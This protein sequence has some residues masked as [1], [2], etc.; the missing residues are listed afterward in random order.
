[1]FLMAKQDPGASAIAAR[2]HTLFFLATPHRGS[3]FASTLNNLLKLA[4]GHGSKFYVDDLYPH[5]E[6]IQ[7][8]ND[9][10]RHVYQG[11]NLYSFFETVPTTLGLIV[12]KTSAVLELPGEQISHL[13]ADHSHVCKFDTPSDSDYIRLRDAFVSTIS[14]IQKT[15]LETQNH[16]RIDDLET[17]SRY[18]G[19]KEQ[20][21]V[22]HANIIEH[23][24]AGSCS[25]LTDNDTF[26]EWMEDI[27]KSPRC[28]WL[29]GEPGSGKSTLASHVVNYLEVSNNN[30]AYFFFKHLHTGK[31]TQKLLD[32]CGGGVA[33][34][35]K[36]ERSIWR[37]IFATRILCVQF[38][39]PQYWVIDGLDECANPASL[40]PLLAKIEKKVWLRVFVTSRPSLVFE[41]AFSRED[42]A[43][44]AETIPL[45]A[46]LSDIRLYLNEHSSYFLCESEDE[47]QELVHT[48]L[49]MSNGN[50]LWT[51]LVVKRIENAVSKEQVHTILNSVPKEMDQLYREITSSIMASP[52]TAPIAKA[53]LR[54]TL[55]SLQPLSVDELREAL[56][57]DIGENLNQLDKTAGAI[58]GNLVYDDFEYGMQREREHTRIT[59]V[60]LAYLS[61]DDMK[62]RRFRRANSHAHKEAKRSIFS[63]YAIVYFSDHI[64][65]SSSSSGEQLAALNKFLMSN[66]TTWIEAIASTKDLTPLTQ[67]ANNLKAYMDRRAK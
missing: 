47:R 43:S 62:P 61:G 39:Q 18:L 44:I 67:T 10:F 49:D 3:N 42:I 8:I 4:V 53:I 28:Y 17:L 24:V 29:R 50:F 21:G 38:Q 51:D 2:I 57:L 40:F 45:D 65:H 30:C 7:T 26:H 25:W 55:C 11:L 23:Q 20:P 5:S 59:E 1:M 14:L 12:E 54:W 32:M 13:N 37:T 52:E 16:K 63:I 36:D 31:S 34:D 19:L 22:D 27:D 9:Q 33:I 46:T 35:R 66:S 48:I 64:A 15:C 6:A 56:R 60:C 58:C 41:R